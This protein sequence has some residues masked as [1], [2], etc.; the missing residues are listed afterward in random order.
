MLDVPEECL[1][2]SPI[3]I[4]DAERFLAAA[5]AWDVKSHHYY[6]PRLLFGGQKKGRLLLF[7]EI[8]GSILIYVLRQRPQDGRLELRLYLPP[9]PFLTLALKQA[10]ERMR[11][12]NGA[13]AACIDFVQDADASL[14]THAGFAMRPVERVFVYDRAAVAEASGSAFKRLRQNL[15]TL[16]NRHGPQPACARYKQPVVS[17]TA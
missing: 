4:G 5:A 9:F 6:F 8:G 2:L 3:Q 12:F 13:R 16:K 10:M 11:S 7:E 1:D 15:V 17:S 14:L